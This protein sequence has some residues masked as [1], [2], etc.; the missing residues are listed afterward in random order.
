VFRSDGL[1]SN[2][3]DGNNSSNN[4]N[5]NNGS[6]NN[7]SNNNGSNSNC[8][9]RDGRQQVVQGSDLDQDDEA[10]QKVLP[11]VQTLFVVP[12]A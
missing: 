4:N 3:S 8:I 9:D 6:N 1:Y 12:M 7:S 5:N 10:Q 2:N 11:D